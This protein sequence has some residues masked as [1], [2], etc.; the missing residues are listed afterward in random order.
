MDFILSV[1]IWKFV[2]GRSLLLVF[3]KKLLKTVNFIFMLL[4]YVMRIWADFFFWQQ[5]NILHVKINKFK[6]KHCCRMVMALCM[7]HGAKVLAGLGSS[8]MWPYCEHLTL[9][10]NVRCMHRVHISFGWQKGYSLLQA[11]C[12]NRLWVN[13]VILC[14]LQDQCWWLPCSWTSSTAL[15][16]GRFLMLLCSC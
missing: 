1:L 11:V 8:F 16:S 5:E 6:K 15:F 10:K 3:R 13:F 9:Q 12:W 14:W 4:C 2:T 7:W